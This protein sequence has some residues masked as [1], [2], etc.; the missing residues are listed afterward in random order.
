MTLLQR[1]RRSNKRPTSKVG[2]R[3]AALADRS[4]CETPP[5]G[6]NPKPTESIYFPVE[7]TDPTCG[8]GNIICKSA[9][10]WNMLLLR[11][12]N[13]RTFLGSQIQGFRIETL[14]LALLRAGVSPQQ[15]ICWMLEWLIFLRTIRSPHK[16]NIDEYRIDSEMYSCI[17]SDF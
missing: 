4:G 14:I 5:T 13:I 6:C 17:P 7:L 3:V 1:T 2:Y 12:V 15:V 10:V 11:R 16:K 9:S 8:K